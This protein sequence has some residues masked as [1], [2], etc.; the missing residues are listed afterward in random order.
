[1]KGYHKAKGFVYCNLSRLSLEDTRDIPSALKYANDAI[2]VNYSEVS[3]VERKAP[4]SHYSKCI[5]RQHSGVLA[6]PL[7]ACKV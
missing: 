6:S 5:N 1:M 7:E 4:Q 2:D 3:K